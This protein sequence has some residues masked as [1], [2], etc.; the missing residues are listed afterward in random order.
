[1]DQRLPFELEYPPIE[2]GLNQWTW[3]MRHDGLRCIEDVKL[4]RG[5]GG[6]SVVPGQYFAR[7]S[8]DGAESAAEIS[9]LPDPRVE[10]DDADYAFL[11]AQLADVTDMFN[12]LIDS[13]A[14]ARKARSQTGA[15]MED[16]PDAGVLQASGVSAV[17]RLTA[18]ENTVTQT[19]YGTFEDEDSMAPMLDVQLRHLLDV[20]D[21]A[22]APVAAGALLRL[23]D[24]RNQW[25]ERKAALDDIATSDLSRINAWA[26]DAGV[27][28]VS[29][30][31]Q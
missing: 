11:D 20:F 24:L 9:L 29:V 12:E 1:M 23:E 10:A 16:F 3:D 15:L 19:L 5:F 18:W 8:I 25:E 26:I 4:F 6:A 28:H 30:P 13:L 31:A 2:P 17:E 27:R 21:Q 14:A 22:G 7:V